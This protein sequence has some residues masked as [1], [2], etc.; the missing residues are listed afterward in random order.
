MVF[1]AGDI[2]IINNNDFES[3]FM[4]MSLFEEEDEEL[5]LFIRRQHA[6]LTA[7]V[8]K[9]LQSDAHGKQTLR[10]TIHHVCGAFR[11][12]FIFST[13]SHA[14]QGDDSFDTN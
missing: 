12:T 4:R 1:S 7:P 5:A 8:M 10:R 13:P 3:L 14:A 2:D 11:A 9:I 6:I